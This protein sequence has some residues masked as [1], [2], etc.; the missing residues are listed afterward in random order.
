[1]TSRIRCRMRRFTSRLKV[2]NRTHC[3]SWSCRKLIRHL[4]CILKLY[5]NFRLEH[6]YG[7]HNAFAVFKADDSGYIDLKRDAPLR[8]T[9]AGTS[10][11]CSFHFCTLRVSLGADPMG[12]FLSQ[13]ATPDFP[14]GGYLRCTPPIPFY[15]D[16]A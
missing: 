8:G 1:M 16:L 10:Y 3:T 15:Y 13:R 5:E 2:L 4:K 6:L 9:Y 14:Y 12:L 7:K 11:P